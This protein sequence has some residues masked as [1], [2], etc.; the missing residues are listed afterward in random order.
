M[1]FTQI[2]PLTF[3][4]K[5]K[6]S[7]NPPSLLL[8]MCTIPTQW[9][10]KHQIQMMEELLSSLQTMD[11]T[12]ITAVKATLWRIHKGPLGDKIFSKTTTAQE[13][14]LEKTT[15]TYLHDVFPL[16]KQRNTYPQRKVSLTPQE[17]GLSTSYRS[18]QNLIIVDSP[19]TSPRWWSAPFPWNTCFKCQSSQ[20]TVIHCP[21]YKCWWCN[22]TAPGHYQSKCL[23]HPRNQPHVFENCDDYD[24]YISADTDYNLSGECWII[25]QLITNNPM[26]H[27]LFIQTPFSRLFPTKLCLSSLF[28]LLT[29]LLSLS[30][31]LETISST[32]SLEETS[33]FWPRLS[34]SASTSTS[35]NGNP[36]TSKPSSKLLPLLDL[37]PIL[38]LTSLTM[39]NPDELELFLSIMYNPKY[40]IYNLSMGQWFDIQSYASIWQFPEMYTLTEWEIK[41]LWIKEMNDPVAT[42]M[43][44]AYEIQHHK[45]YHWLLG[46]IYE[47]SEWDQGSQPSAGVMLCYLSLGVHL[48]PISLFLPHPHPLVL[49]VPQI[50]LCFHLFW[51]PW[52]LCDLLASPL[53]HV[54]LPTFIFLQSSLYSSCL[55]VF[56]CTIT[57]LLLIGLLTWLL[58]LLCLTFSSCIVDQ[59]GPSVT[60]YK[61]Q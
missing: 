40:N 54:L 49:F 17:T 12:H 3:H 51:I 60:L 45:C 55:I 28:L 42:E 44:W 7:M 22:W 36:S 15:T 16:Q 30:N 41:N 52:S 1:T 33:I 34:N 38:P 61:P 2:K 48:A 10:I 35:L 5:P 57:H 18:W 39:I 47:D 21:S 20:H 4:L 31:P 6:S 25:C 59:Y 8:T 11:K 37:Y 50:T 43:F 29:L 13:N 53:P 23:E 19:P 27:L 14:G 46:S 58:I 32:T 26:P 24:D 9:S 56:S